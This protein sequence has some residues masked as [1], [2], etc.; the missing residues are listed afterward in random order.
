MIFFF[1][2]R[3][4]S[5]FRPSVRQ[6]ARRLCR[7]ARFIRM[8]HGRKGSRFEKLNCSVFKYN[9]F[10]LVGVERRFRRRDGRFRPAVRFSRSPSVGL[11]AVPRRANLARLLRGAVFNPFEALGSGSMG[12][13]DSDGTLLTQVK[14]EVVDKKKS[15]LN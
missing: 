4:R 9:Y 12:P 10:T 7:L 5:V 13:Y 6:P 3:G 15:R 1:Y 11:A 2:Q 14:S 8:G